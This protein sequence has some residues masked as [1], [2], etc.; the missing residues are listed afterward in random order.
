MSKRILVINGH[1][2]ASPQ[3]YCAAVAQAYADGAT[4]R[5]AEVRRLSIGELEFPL[6]RC[7]AD[8]EDVDPPSCITSAQ[9][10]FVWAE[11]VVLV[12]PLWLGAAPAFLK[13]FFEQAFRYGF[14][15]PQPGEEI[16]RGKLAGRSA[17]LIVTMG[18]PGALYASLFGGFGVRAMKRGILGLAGF[19]PIEH[20]YI[21][22]VETSADARR[23]WLDKVRRLGA[24]DV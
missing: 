18:M 6:I 17:R 13:A 2:D 8:F 19:K 22:N 5:G 3:R 4:E 24:A 21:G 11:H 15:V 23:D 14:A 12:H 1:P 16:P 9:D 7:R 20:T 10:A